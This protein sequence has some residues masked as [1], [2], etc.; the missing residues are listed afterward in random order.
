D[1]THFPVQLMLLTETGAKPQWE[2]V[3]S[4]LSREFDLAQIYIYPTRITADR[5]FGITFGNFSSRE[6]ALAALAKLPASY[7]SNRPTLRTVK[8]IRAEIAKQNIAGAT[9]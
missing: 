2:S 6:Q 8:G 7:R 1:G 5:Q 4:G 3:L 9:L